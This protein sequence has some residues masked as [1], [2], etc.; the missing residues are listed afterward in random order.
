M[1]MISS[2]NPAMSLQCYFQFAMRK[3]LGNWLESDFQRL[4]LGTFLFLLIYWFD[5]FSCFTNFFP[6]PSCQLLISPV[7]HHDRV[8]SLLFHCS[9][10]KGILKINI[11]RIIMELKFKVHCKLWFTVLNNPWKGKTE[12][13]LGSHFTLN[14]VLMQMVDG[15]LE[16]TKS[17]R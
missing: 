13:D 6:L 10:M 15:F 11:H 9:I 8:Q 17:C 5:Y 16:M 4:L 14:G 12:N 7:T 2:S 3:W 1:V